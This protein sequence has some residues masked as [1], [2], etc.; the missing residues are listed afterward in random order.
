MDITIDIDSLNYMSYQP[1]YGGTFQPGFPSR[2]ITDT[3]MCIEA[4]GSTLPPLLR[5]QSP[6]ALRHGA[7]RH[8][9]PGPFLRVTYV[10]ALDVC[11]LQRCRTDN[12]NSTSNHICAHPVGRAVRPAR[13]LAGERGR[14][15]D[16]IGMYVHTYS[17]LSTANT[18][19]WDR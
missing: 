19:G 18:S 6:R 1:T 5:R 9:D 14:D 2:L 15:R 4:H 17:T 7:V 3:Q 13:S 12:P 16:R 10:C 8:P 11:L